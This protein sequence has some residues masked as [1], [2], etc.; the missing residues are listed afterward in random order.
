MVLSESWLTE[1]MAPG[2]G[3]LC[4]IDDGRY[5]NDVNPDEMPNVGTCLHDRLAALGQFSLGRGLWAASFCSGQ[6]ILPQDR[7]AFCI[8]TRAGFWIDF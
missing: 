3:V 8:H 6:H 4:E 7:E 1:Q 5:V 2:D